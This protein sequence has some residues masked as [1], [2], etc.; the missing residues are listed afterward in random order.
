MN[1][2]QLAEE[3]ISLIGGKENINSL[4]H[5]ATRLRFN[6]AD[7]EKAD[8]D[9]L[10]AVRGVLGV[11]QS[12]GQFQIIIG[13]DVAHVYKAVN[14]AAG[15][16]ENKAEESSGKKEKGTKGIASRFLD[17]VSSIFTPVLPAITAAGMLKAV[18]SLL[19]AFHLV[20]SNSQSYQ[21]ISFMA[22][23]AFYFLP[24]LL[25]NS[26]AK[27]FGCNPYLAIMVGGIL[28]HP[29]F[30]NMLSEAAKSEEALKLFV[31]PIYDAS[32][33]STVVPIIL[34]VW[35]MS[36]VQPVAE[37]ISPKPVKYFT[38]PLITVLVTGVAALTVLGPIGYIIG[39]SIAAGINLLE[40]Y[41]SW[42]V[43][44]L[45]G[46]LF[47]LM[48]MTGT[49]YG[50]VP[51]GANN[52][53]SLGYDALIGPGA[54]ASNVAQGGAALAVAVKTRNKEMKSLAYSSGITAVCGITEPALYGVNARFKTPLYAAIAGGATG[55]LIAGI[56]HV[57][58][59]ST[60]ASGLITLPIYLGESGISNLMFAVA[61]A[62][63]AFIVGFIGSFILYKEQKN[64][65]EKQSEAVISDTAQTAVSEQ[66]GIITAP[67]D[68][69][70]IPLSEVGDPTFAQELIGKGVAVIPESD[71]IVSP[72]DG[73]VSMLFPTKHAVGLLADSGEEMLIHI[74]IDT[75]KLEG[76]YFE[77][78]VQTEDRVK[79]GQ[80]LIRVDFA[81]VKAA[82]YDITTPVLITNHEDFRELNCTDAEE[83]KAGER[84][85]ETVK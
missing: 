11:V 26:C 73:T 39:D 40:S 17:T 70:V 38:M 67:A 84:L 5:C 77:S 66:K 44:T 9:K 55:G 68:G 30:V 6:L 32:Y 81:G 15:I 65:I 83:V 27:K 49:H 79:A 3:I 52:V 13:N 54:L 43:P 51:I 20:N 4:V 18:L 8:I 74:G 37:R 7:E 28:L 19:V 16:T 61:A 31:L 58:R 63:A 10:K 57:K 22:D 56:F 29:D 82:G 41:A 64:E 60:G 85:M 12:G 62:A 71:T 34:S 36:H 53:L 78:L 59:F 2:E 69:K 25:A 46:G 42:L 50:V 21:I 76:K 47:P 23:A 24:I 75:V 45:I 14:Q 1:Y 72:A 80:P 33:S 35:F 48:V